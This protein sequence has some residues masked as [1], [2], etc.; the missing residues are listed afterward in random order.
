MVNELGVLI[1]SFEGSDSIQDC[2]LEL[3]Q[4]LA[5]LLVFDKLTRDSQLR[6]EC[7]LQVHRLLK[8]L[9]LVLGHL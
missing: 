3:S 7:F 8:R 1:G 5:E 2:T 9:S 4:L 6:L